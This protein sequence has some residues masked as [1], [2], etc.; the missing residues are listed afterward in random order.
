MA[1]IK[2]T[3][4]VNMLN[5]VIA[6]DKITIVVGTQ[7]GC[8]HCPPWIKKLQKNPPPGVAIVEIPS[9]NGKPTCEAIQQKLKVKFTPHTTIFKSGRKM[10]NF[11]PKGQSV[12]ENYAA[13]KAKIAKYQNSSSRKRRNT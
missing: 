10:S 2:K 9:N 12:N 8:H 7:K 6:S 11:N 3:C 4:D 5:K 1:A 13:L